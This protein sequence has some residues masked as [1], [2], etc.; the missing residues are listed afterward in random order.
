MNRIGKGAKQARWIWFTG[1]FFASLYVT[2]VG[3]AAEMG[4]PGGGEPGTESQQISWTEIEFDDQGLLYSTA[5]LNNTISHIREL[6]KN[7][8]PLRLVLFVH[9]WHND[10]DPE[11]TTGNY[12]DFPKLLRGFA[13]AS[14]DADVF[15][16]F[17]G[18]R[19]RSIGWPLL[20]WFTFFSRLE[21]AARVARPACSEALLAILT[22][23]RLEFADRLDSLDSVVIGHSM[24]GLIVEE[25]LGKAMLGSMFAQL[26]AIRFA[27]ETQDKLNE[28]QSSAGS[29]LRER[30]KSA[31][32]SNDVLNRIEGARRACAGLRAVPALLGSTVCSGQSAEEKAACNRGNALLQEL[33]R[34]DQRME[35]V[36]LG[37]LDLGPC[38]M[39]SAPR[40]REAAQDSLD[41]LRRKL[42]LYLEDAAQVL[43]EEKL[44]ENQAAQDFYQAAKNLGSSIPTAPRPPLA[45]PSELQSLGDLIL[46]V[47][48][49]LNRRRAALLTRLEKELARKSRELWG[50]VDQAGAILKSLASTVK[51]MPTL[52]QPPADLVLL[53]N[54]ASR[55][56]VARSL[57]GGLNHLHETFY[58]NNP[59]TPW[60]IDLQRPWL[61]SVSSES[62][63]ATSDLLPVAMT[64]A[65]KWQKFREDCELRQALNI[66]GSALC[67]PNGRSTT[68]LPPIRGDR[69]RGLLYTNEHVMLRRAAPH[70][71]VLLSHT[72]VEDEPQSQRPGPEDPE[73]LKNIIAQNLTTPAS[74]RDRL[75]LTTCTHSY[76][77]KEVDAQKWNETGYWVIQAPES[78]I[79]GHSD[80]FKSD[81][82]ALV[83]SLIRISKA[84]EPREQP[85][86]PKVTPPLGGAVSVQNP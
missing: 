14:K 67:S 74:A 34:I 76:R 10:A 29:L 17:V 50:E 70:I 48:D 60:F 28:A 64:W 82:Y 26:P 1:V 86:E 83:A 85:G 72:L 12:V 33:D 37:S 8:K 58:F 3:Y 22:A 56:I 55:G 66:P 4:T 39:L 23:A 75:R 46:A 2:T 78:L 21:A 40:Y 13:G 73:C 61:V 36:D 79:A 30:T 54:P 31:Q 59:A 32:D 15:G 53:I 81:F 62:D 11:K 41:R 84:F 47:D 43:Q 63:S 5:A 7:N 20:R 35:G 45:Q 25:A 6:A 49:S 71:P 51:Q 44:P 18:W 65:S 69:D 52:W 77:F 16:V 38:T 68:S 9:G 27:H 80:I 24:G 57:I 19:G 42:E